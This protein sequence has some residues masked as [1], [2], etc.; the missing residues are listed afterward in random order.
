MTGESLVRDALAPARFS[1]A[2]LGAFAVVALLLAMVGLYGVIAY[3]VTQRT[4]EIGVRT[5][6]GAS[7]SAVAR[8]I[9]GDGLR[10]VGAGLAVG[11]AAA[12]A[13]S[14]VI[15]SLLYGMSPLD[16]V[17]YLG[18]SG[19]VVVIALIATYAPARRAMRIDPMEA[20]RA[21]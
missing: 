17:T 19:V 10:L 15:T 1:M 2:L 4:R 3:G 8:L 20:L 21:E 12:A 14:R 5:A 6:L 16:P 11:L 13:T 7:S 18:I 9:V